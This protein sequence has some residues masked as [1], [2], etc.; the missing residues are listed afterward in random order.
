MRL[1]FV[2]CCLKGEKLR[3]A[4][5]DSIAVAG[6]DIDIREDRITTIIGPNGSGKRT[7]PLIAYKEIV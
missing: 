6:M 3:I 5:G 4:Y 2:R 1:L 7:K